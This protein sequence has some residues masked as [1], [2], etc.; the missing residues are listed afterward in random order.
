MSGKD[1]RAITIAISSRRRISSSRR[2]LEASRL[3][4][5][6]PLDVDPARKYVFATDVNTAR[7]L[8]GLKALQGAEQRMMLRDAV[9]QHVKQNGF[10][11]AT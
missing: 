7:R 8:V 4:P 6:L 9:I 2:W 1:C 11:R 5:N 10:P 3:P